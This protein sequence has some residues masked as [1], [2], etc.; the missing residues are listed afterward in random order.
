MRSIGRWPFLVG[1][2][3]VATVLLLLFAD[4]G[5]ATWSHAT[6][7]EPGREGLKRGFIAL[8]HLIDPLVP[9]S[10]LGL[11]VLGGM[12]AGAVSPFRHGRLILAACAATLVAV[13]VKDELKFAFGRMW[14]ETWTN[15]NP[16][17]I[18]NGA[19]GFVPFHGGTGWSSFPSGHMTVI[20]AP[21]V[22]VMLAEPNWRWLAALPVVLVALGLY[23]SDYHFLSDM[24]AGV[25]V[26]GICAGVIWT[27]FDRPT[28]RGSARPSHDGSLP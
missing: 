16:S 26:G 19:F 2:D 21:M 10:I 7:G 25:L 1:A 5:A 20:T 11:L 12:A 14:P 3:V 24:L 17:W 22:I 8:T 18:A 23:G 6:F 15:N 4:R 27:A 9:L 28:V 13:A